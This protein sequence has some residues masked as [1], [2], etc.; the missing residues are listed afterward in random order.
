MVSTRAQT[1][2]PVAEA[3]SGRVIPRSEASRD[4][5]ASPSGMASNLTDTLTRLQGY[6]DTVYKERV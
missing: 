3:R 2:Q 5:Q 1:R 4:V 6:T